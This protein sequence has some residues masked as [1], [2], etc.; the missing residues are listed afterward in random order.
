MT[1]SSTEDW[2]NNKITMTIDLYRNI[3]FNTLLVFV[4]ILYKITQLDFLA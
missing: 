3:K 4:Q 1:L 2:M